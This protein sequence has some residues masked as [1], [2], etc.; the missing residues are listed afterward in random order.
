MATASSSNDGSSSSCSSIDPLTSSSGCCR[1]TGVK[2]A[3]APSVPSS[4]MT[5]AALTPSVPSRPA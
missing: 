2:G 5:G 1:S 3:A 4:M